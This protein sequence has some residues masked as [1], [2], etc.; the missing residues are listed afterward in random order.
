MILLLS[1]PNSPIRCLCIFGDAFSH[2]SK[3]LSVTFSIKEEN[4]L[5][6][7]LILYYLQA[8]LLSFRCL[9]IF[10]DAFSQIESVN[11]GSPQAYQACRRR[12]CYQSLPRLLPFRR[13][14]PLPIVVAAGPVEFFHHSIIPTREAIV[15][16]RM[17]LSNEAIPQNLDGRRPESWRWLSGLSRETSWW[18]PAGPESETRCY[19]GGIDIGDYCAFPTCPGNPRGIVSAPAL[20]SFA[21]SFHHHL[22]SH[23]ICFSSSA[24]RRVSLSFCVYTSVSRFPFLSFS[25]SLLPLLYILYLSIPVNQEMRSRIRENFLRENQ[26]ICRLAR[27]QR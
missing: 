12:L 1:S 8:L 21:R 6:P 23:T 11:H 22:L 20:R 15:P 19:G 26:S 25:L 27:K 10:G 14:L 5:Y 7:Q 13:P 17:G 9:S 3:I 24:R 2:I 16:V 4:I 18:G